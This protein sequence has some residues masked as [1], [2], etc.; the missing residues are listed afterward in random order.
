MHVLPCQRT[1]LPCAAVMSCLARPRGPVL[2]EGGVQAG[3]HDGCPQ[4]AHDD[5]ALVRTTHCRGQ[6]PARAL[7]VIHRGDRRGRGLRA[8]NFVKFF[9]RETRVIRGRSDDNTCA[10]R[11]PFARCTRGGDRYAQPR[12]Q[13]RRSTSSRTPARRL[14][15][16]NQA[17]REVMIGRLPHSRAPNVRTIS[18][19]SSGIAIA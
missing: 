19:A 14:E 18:T 11:E 8:T 4:V 15:L 3:G 2:G 16:R 7:G 1:R 17:A 5:A 6:A 10:L 12:S 13:R 9:K